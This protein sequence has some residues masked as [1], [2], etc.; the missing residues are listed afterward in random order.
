MVESPRNRLLALRL[1]RTE[2]ELH[3]AQEL[4]YRVFYEEMGATPSPEMA[5]VRRDFDSFDPVCDHIVVVDEERGPPDRPYVVGCYRLMLG[6]VAREWGGFYTSGE[7]DLGGLLRF[8]G[9]VLE[10]GRSCVDPAYRGGPIMQ[11]LWRGIADYVLDHDV[12]L[13]F[14]C[15]SLPGTDPRAVAAILTYLHHERMAPEEIKPR[16]V[17]GRYVPLDQMPVAEIDPQAVWNALPPLLKGYL[18][19]G[20]WVGDG[21]VI[22]EQFNTIDV[23]VVLPTDEVKARYQ[24]HYRHGHQARQAA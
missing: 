8:P 23:C 4:R 5:A 18:R 22:D 1:V 19:L 20:G 12:K 11:M 9:E 2:A 13:M 14:G 15:A 7:F 21:A 3:A 10:L 6:R 24:R 17:P 16:A